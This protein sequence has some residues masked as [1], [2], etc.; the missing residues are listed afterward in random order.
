MNIMKKISVTI[1]THKRHNFLKKM[2]LSLANQTLNKSEYE[3]LICD[4]NSGTETNEV[5]EEIRCV[6]PQLDLR[7]IHTVNILAAKRN[8]G[9]R[10]S[11]Y[12][13]IIFLDDDCL[14]ERD[15]LERHRAYFDNDSI[16][17]RSMK[18]A[19]GE[20]RFPKEWIKKSNYYKF[21]DE[22]GFNF[23]K[24]HSQKLD[25]KTIV[26]M[27]MSFLKQQFVDN[28]YGVNENFIGYGMEDQEL[29][30]RLEKAGF[31]IL[32]TDARVFHHEMS[33]DI[34]GY[35]KKIFHTARDGAATLLNECPEAFKAIN[36]L[37]LIDP[38]YPFNSILTLF[39]YRCAR[40]IIFNKLLQSVFVKWVALTEKIPY[41]YS[42]NIYRYILANYYIAGANERGRCKPSENNWYS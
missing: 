38:D 36:K 18:I 11:K 13:I 15:Y 40:K 1:A 34:Q 22:E 17:D 41:L 20:V 33:N 19:C 4:S 7:H 14:M 39:V 27:N 35:G 23:K 37:K 30:W 32:G 10:E 28:V 9:I 24:S 29:G 5:I 21:R 42:K 25:F 8:L 12:E 3:I 6:C 16:N 2:I 26:V 31:E